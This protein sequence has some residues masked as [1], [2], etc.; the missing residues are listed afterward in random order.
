MM[1]D[2]AA[3]EDWKS[4]IKARQEDL[5]LYLLSGEISLLRNMDH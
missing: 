3:Y 1:E 4:D 2:P 5:R